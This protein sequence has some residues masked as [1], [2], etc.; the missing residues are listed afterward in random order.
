MGAMKAKLDSYLRTLIKNKGSDL[1]VK[2]GG[3]PRVRISGALRKIGKDTLDARDLEA[4][5]KEIST[6]EQFKKLQVEKSL[7]MSYL[8]GDEARFRA[9]VFYQMN[10]LSIVMRIIPVK[11]PNFEEMGLPKVLAKFADVARGMV[12]V[13]GV[14]GSGKSTTLAAII[15]KIN[16]TYPKH[17]ITLED[18][19]E[20]VHPDKKCLINQRSIG[21]D[22]NSFADALPAAL[23]EDPDIILVG[24]MR[25]VETI[26]LALHAAGTGHLV[27]STLH[28]LDAKET[29]DRIVGTFPEE[30]QNRIRQSLS[31]V[32]EGTITQ[33]LVPTV[34]GGR[35]AAV[36]VMVKT[37]R[38][39]ELIANSEDAE[40][41]DAIAEG[42]DIYGSQTFDQHLYDLVKSGRV[43]EEVA[44]EFATSPSDLKLLLEGIGGG[45]ASSGGEEDGEVE[46]DAYDF[47]DDSDD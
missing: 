31:S 35:V 29:I 23:R 8:L 43:K 19:I 22:S 33:R 14:T 15:D 26:E 41:P 11:I 32:L 24:E 17:I 21:Q 6:D 30:E 47:K 4:M 10:G 9:N 27:F 2:S 36:E 39:S 42:R 40:I 5:V 45:G 44:M 46:L 34:D 7:D 1:H 16:R 3:I 18:P 20:F 38:I 25:D 13:T 37:P 12:L 28:T